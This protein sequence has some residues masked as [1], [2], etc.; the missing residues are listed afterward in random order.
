M[1]KIKHLLT[2]LTV[3]IGTSALAAEAPINMICVTEIPTSTFEAKENGNNVHIRLIHHNGTKFAPISKAILT[4]NDLEPLQK[5]AEMILKLGNKWEFDWDRSGCNADEPMFFQC[6]GGAKDFEING[7]KIH[8]WAFSVSE[9]TEKTIWGTYQ[10]KN[11]SLRFD[12]DKVQY[13]ITMDYQP[14]E[15]V[16]LQGNSMKLQPSRAFSN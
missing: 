8:P 16:Q 15:C 3:L 14:G 12:I 13:E 11:V 6:V 1:Q 5:R 2:T 10:Q 4:P 9:L 7:V